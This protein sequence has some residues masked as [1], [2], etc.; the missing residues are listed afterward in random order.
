MSDRQIHRKMAKRTVQIKR[1][2]YSLSLSL[3][4]FFLYF[5]FHIIK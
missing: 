2:F 3:Y 1:G 5:V 4:F